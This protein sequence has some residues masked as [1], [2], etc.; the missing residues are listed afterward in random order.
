VGVT[1][2][3]VA[4]GI[5]STNA[6]LTVTEAPTVSIAFLRTLVDPGTFQAPANSTQPYKVTG[7]VT[8]YT[9]LTQSTRHPI[10]LQDG[11]GWHQ[12]LC[13]IWPNVPSRTGRHRDVCRGGIELQ[14]RFGAV[15]RHR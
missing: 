14:Q 6:T 1:N 5:L 13:Y 8:T 3:V 4:N 2:D 12:H 11:T 7:T 15:C 9:N 10:Y